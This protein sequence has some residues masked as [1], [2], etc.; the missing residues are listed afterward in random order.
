[1]K[2]PELKLSY[3]ANNRRRILRRNPRELSDC[4]K[5]LAN[6]VCCPCVTI[7]NIIFGICVLC[8]CTN[9]KWKLITI[10]KIRRVLIR[11]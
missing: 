6:I 1:M 10:R 11:N 5:C 9:K 4:G 2:L 7:A 3:I 8:K